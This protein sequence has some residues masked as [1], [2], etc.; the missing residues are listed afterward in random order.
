MKKRLIFILFFVIFLVSCNKNE[1]LNI[2]FNNEPK[3]EYIEGTSTEEALKDITIKIQR[4]KNTQIVN[5]K[6]MK[7]EGFDLS[8]IGEHVMIVKYEGKE[9][10]WK[11]NVVVKPWDGSIDT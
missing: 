4:K 8:T 10:S 11:Y 7:I 2:S 3:K 6:D 1:L 9:L 5:A